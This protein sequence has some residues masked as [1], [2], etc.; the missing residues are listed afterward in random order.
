MITRIVKLTF[1]EESVDSFIKLFEDT[2]VAISNFKGC[3]EVRLMKDV[4]N[5]V[6]FFT[7][8]KWDSELFL[9]EYRNS[10]FFE[11]VWTQTK[12]YFDAKPEA[13]TL[14]ECGNV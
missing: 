9:N 7:V 2:Q 14:E 4:S 6:V 12:L 11:K 13:W 3:K 5:P 8:S 1:K 10:P